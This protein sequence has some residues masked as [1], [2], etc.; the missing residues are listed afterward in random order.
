MKKILTIILTTVFLFTLVAI[1]V[2]AVNYDDQVAPCFNNTIQAT[3]NFNISESG[4]ATVNL[5]YIGYPNT[6]TGATI[7]CSVEKST[8]SGWVTVNGASWTD[9]VTGFTNTVQHTVQLTSRGTY[10]MVYEYEIRG[11]GGAA[12]IISDTI[13]KTY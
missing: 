13:E 8:S 11:T 10:R 4:L 5:K 12:D 2:S 6:A 3:S 9:E 7:T 1:P